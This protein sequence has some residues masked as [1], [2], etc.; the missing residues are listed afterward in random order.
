MIGHGISVTGLG[1]VSGPDGGLAPL[2]ARLRDG[3]AATS[4]INRRQGYHL[5]ESARLAV[6]ADGVDLSMW[7]SSAVARRMSRPSRLAVAAARMALVDAG[8]GESI[9]GSRTGVVMSTAFGAVEST[10]K[11]LEAVRL[12]GP[13]A[14]SPFMFA[15]S[16]ANAAAGQVAIDA[17]ARGPNITIVQREAGVLTAVGRGAALVSSGRCDRV[18]VGSVDEMPP[19]LHALLDRF[20]ALARPGDAGGEIARPFDRAR[21]GFVAAE[22]AA[23]LILEREDLARARGARVRARVRAFASAFDHTAPRIGWGRDH[24]SLSSALSTM[25]RRAGVATSDLTHI[26]SGASGAVVGD[27]LEA[28]T[29][30]GAWRGTLLPPVLTPKAWVGQYG[31]G[32][33]AASILAAEGAVFGPTPGFTSEDPEIG[34]RPHG[35]GA[36]PS[37]ALSLITALASGGAAAWLILEQG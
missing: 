4:A 35:G 1:V 5:E 11:I 12:E 7:V 25:L 9:E 29:L 3:E 23:V 8:L 28:K 13:L 34:V 20:D 2:M 36:L 30:K 17:K 22:G 16:V 32:F 18:I 10:E 14:A 27:R 31:G 6:L 33:L 15:E 21:T 19:V 37:T 24:A 26:V